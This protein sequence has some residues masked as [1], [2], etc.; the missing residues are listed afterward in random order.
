MATVTIKPDP[1]DPETFVL[2]TNLTAG[3]GGGWN[4]PPLGPPPPYTAKF[5]RTDV[6]NVGIAVAQYA[7]AKGAEGAGGPSAGQGVTFEFTGG[8]GGEGF[9]PAPSGGAGGNV[10]LNGGPGG[11]G[12]DGAANGPPGDVVL[13]GAPGRFSTDGGFSGFG[14]VRLLGG[15]EDS[16]ILVRTGGIELTADVV[17]TK[18]SW[19]V[20]AGGYPLTFVAGSGA[21]GDDFGAGGPGGDL[22]LSAGPGGPSGGAGGGGPDGRVTIRAGDALTNITIQPGFVEVTAASVAFFSG[23]TFAGSVAAV[24]FA[25]DGSSLSGI[26]QLSAVNVWTAANTFKGGLSAPGAGASSEAI[27][28][29]AATG[30]ATFATA[31]GAGATVT[32]PAGTAIGAGASAKQ[33]GVAIGRGVSAGD[34]GLSIGYQIV[35]AGTGV[36]IGADLTAPP[37]GH[38]FGSQWKGSGYD[39]FCFGYGSGVALPAVNFTTFLGGSPDEKTGHT[40]R[41][42]GQTGTNVGRGLFD[43]AGTWV[44]NTDATRK[45]RVRFGVFDFGSDLLSRE[46]MRAESDG[47]NA[48]V[49]AVGKF[50]APGVGANSLRVGSGAVASADYA[51]ALGPNANATKAG[52]ITISGTASGANSFAFGLS[53]SAAADGAAAVGDH[54]QAKAVNS[55]AMG[56]Y[57]LTDTGG[58]AAIGSNVRA[59]HTGSV[60]FGTGGGADTGTGA[61]GQFVYHYAAAAGAPEFILSTDS[62]FQVHRQLVRLRGEWATAA[63]ATRK[64]RALLLVPDSAGWREAWRAE[65]DGAAP[66]VGF[67]GA[68]AVAQQAVGAAAVDAATTQ[69]LANALRTALINLG[70]CK[71]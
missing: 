26:P 51:V 30:A 20:G 45:A 55:L 2:E 43:F 67:L 8:E 32:A 63:D 28:A 33:G 24:S 42:I 7:G 68:A 6:A 41:V 22:T 66:R 36:C 19:A 71:N 60:I 40:L 29:G 5:L 44:D 15:G 62:D 46:F 64:G 27:G 57:C 65:A 23:A 39:Q 3:P 52:A 35:N 38:C 56:A 1:A 48:F 53:S 21:A 25:G 70:L 9:A 49:T 54:A 16:E 4:E 34:F 47:A 17:T 11:W 10:V 18:V 31:I 50:D 12:R 61:A 13:S 37:R 59:T 58:L 14:S 69:A